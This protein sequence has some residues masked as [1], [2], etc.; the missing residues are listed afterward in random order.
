[1]KFAATGKTG[2]NGEIWGK[3][4]TEW[5]LEGLKTS[6]APVKLIA[7]GTQVLSSGTRGE[8]HF[9]EARG[10][11]QRLLDFVAAHKIGGVVFISGDRHYTEAMQL[12]QPDG[13]LVVEGTSSPLQQ[14]QD[15]SHVSRPHGSQLWAMRGNN[16]GIITVD[17]AAEGRGTVRFE[18]RDEN[19]IVPVLYD[20]PRATTWTLD[21]LNYGTE[22]SVPSAWTPIFD[23]TTLDGWT[24]KN[25]TAT[26]RVED[27][28]IV[29]KTADGSPNSFLCTEKEY[30]DFELMF[31]VFVDNSLNS[32][33]QIRSE[34]Y[35][36]Y[37]N[38]RVHGPQI[39]IE[40]SPGEA[41]YIY[42]EGTG[43]GWISR[44]REKNAFRNSSWNHYYV[45]AV[46]S[47][48]QTWING[49]AVADVSEEEM[50][51]S[52]FIGLQVHGIPRGSG[53]YEVKWR[54][55]HVKEWRHSEP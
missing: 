15:V 55:L 5:L 51:R 12:S 27:G 11:R 50:S 33:V 39:E 48:I 16:Y 44:T 41:G 19:N 22:T 6:T 31:D 23:G 54:N 32:G 26:Y 3:A 49:V 45:R 10:E 40:S 4:Q 14:D 24:Q 52:G 35:P 38:G 37:K 13:T 29:G 47:R 43:K 2:E 20:E 1:M 42:S 25:G 18:V 34:S 46:G 17:I 53:P 28:S 9:Q 21:Q 7:N 8:G 30:G 36:D